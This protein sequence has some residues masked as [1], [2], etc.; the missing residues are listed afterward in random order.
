MARDRK[1]VIWF[2]GMTLD[3]HHFQQWDRHQQGV[4]NDRMR[5]VAPHGWGVVHLAFDEERLANG[6]LA[7]RACTGAMPDGLVFNVPDGSPLPETR[8]VQELVPA[9]EERVGVHLAIPATRDGGRNVRLQG[10][11]NQ[12]ETRFVAESVSVSDENTGANERPV[13]VAR[14]NVQ[15]RLASEPQQGYSTMPIAEI[16]RTAGGFALSEDFVP[17]CLQIG[18]SERLMSLARQVIERLVAK[19]GELTDRQ[20]NAASQRE[21]SPSDIKAI[22]LLGAVNT[23]IPLLNNQFNGERHHPERLF[24]TLLALAGQLSAYAGSASVRPR[25]YPSYE[26]ADA[27][28]CFSR[29][30]TILLEMLGEATPSSNYERLSLGRTRE[31]LLTTS[32]RQELLQEAQLFLVT[33][34]DTHSEEQL[35]ASLPN[36]LRIASPD[37]IDA[38]LQSYTKALAVEATRRLPT[39]MPVDNQATYFR[40]EKRGPFWES[41]CDEGGIAIFLPSE[42]TG[43][44]MNLIAA[45]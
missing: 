30:E 34:S 38:V 39:G 43:V 25:D 22:Q 10:G 21:L 41:I 9:T 18:A 36:M 40:L 32:V 33:R 16:V 31:N 1:K 13:E 14:T 12:R 45:T 6:E 15:L 24:E 8:N 35:T 29:I 23:Y 26:H 5:A 42:F 20:R 19:S 28:A 7:L 27:T 17:P 2:E 37:T 11:A 3:P 4:L 44:E